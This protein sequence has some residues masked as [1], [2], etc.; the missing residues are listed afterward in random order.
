MQFKHASL[1][2]I[3]VLLGTAVLTFIVIERQKELDE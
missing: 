2:L 3:V 1:L